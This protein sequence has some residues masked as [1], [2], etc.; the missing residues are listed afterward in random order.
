MDARE[1]ERQVLARCVQVAHDASSVATD[2]REANVL[3]VAGLVCG[4]PYTQ[5][6]QRLLAC[7]RR[8]FEAHPGSRLEPGELVRRGWVTTLPRLR[9]MLHEQL[10]MRVS[11]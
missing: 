10:K 2:A 11:V 1:T 4:R 6:R 7:S 9:D 3:R 8:Y 5:E